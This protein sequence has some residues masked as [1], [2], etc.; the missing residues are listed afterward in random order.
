[1][2]GG[3]GERNGEGK[4]IPV[5]QQQPPLLIFFA[6]NLGGDPFAHFVEAFRHRENP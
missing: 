1:M 6:H 5:Q 2:K 3:R 4:N